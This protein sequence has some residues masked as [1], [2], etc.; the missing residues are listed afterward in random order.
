MPF[1]PHTLWS[2]K[3]DD[4]ILTPCVSLTTC[5]RTL[6]IAFWPS[7]KMRKQVTVSALTRLTHLVFADC[8][9]VQRWWML[10]RAP[11]SGQSGSNSC[12]SDENMKRVFCTICSHY[13]SAS[14]CEESPSMCG[15][16]WKTL[17]KRTD[18]I[19]TYSRLCHTWLRW[20]NALDDLEI[21]NIV[22]LER[23]F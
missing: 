23:D 8:Q 22:H 17:W 16:V 15:Y 12:L 19:F 10:A 21:F 5:T 11:C 20:W 6:P 1:N 9:D 4:F 2:G 7:V 13:I 3:T 18:L 14:W